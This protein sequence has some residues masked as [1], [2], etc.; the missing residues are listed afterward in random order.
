MQSEVL[1]MAARSGRGK[2]DGAPI[3]FRCG[4][5]LLALVVLGSVLAGGC[6]TP[7]SSRGQISPEAIRPASGDT[8]RLLRNAHYFNLMGRPDLALKELEEA[9]QLDPQN[10]KLIEALA[11][12]YEE[13]GEF[14]RAQKLYQ[15]ALN[16]QGSHPALENN[17]CFS[18]YRAGRWEEA[19]ACFRRA[20]ARNPQNSVARNNLG[21]LYCRIGKLEEARRL[22]REAE[23]EI[24]E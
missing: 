24:Q 14:E 8:A 15:E 12:N 1:T 11:R 23:G 16:R 4:A 22:W 10:L 17:L 18:Y 3:L 6:S 20:L 19:E 7:G 13:L 2:R 9:Y 21:L 5:A